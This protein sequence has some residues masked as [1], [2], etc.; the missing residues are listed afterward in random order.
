MGVMFV[1][2]TSAGGGWSCGC[3]ALSG[4]V[5]SILQAY[6]AHSG[7]PSIMLMIAEGLKGCVCVPKGQKVADFLRICAFS[8]IIAL[9]QSFEWIASCGFS[10]ILE[11]GNGVFWVGMLLW[12]REGASYFY[13]VTI[14]FFATGRYV[15]RLTHN[16]L[17][18]V[19]GAID[20]I[21]TCYTP[22]S[23]HGHKGMRRCTGDVAA[24][25]EGKALV[26]LDRWTNGCVSQNRMVMSPQKLLLEL[27]IKILNRPWCRWILFSTLWCNHGM[28]K[29]AICMLLGLPLNIFQVKQIASLKKGFHR[30]TGIPWSSNSCVFK[31]KNMTGAF[32]Q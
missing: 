27:P 20:F 11:D 26:E 30:M 19:T 31:R 29:A 8:V 2:I 28:L 13:W 23:S 17:P 5:L 6:V 14:Y 21:N 3:R 9:T 12:L 18:L 25:Y 4:F 1:L 7:R 10:V 22:Q 15:F 24:S 32:I 16:A